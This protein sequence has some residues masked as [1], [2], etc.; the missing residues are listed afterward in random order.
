MRQLSTI[1]AQCADWLFPPYCCLCN[2]ALPS[3]NQ[4]ICTSCYSALPW[5]NHACRQCALPLESGER[6]GTCLCN[7]PAFAH[8]ITPFRYEPPISTLI[9]QLKFQQQLRY[10]RVLGQLLIE[11]IVK[12][13]HSLPEC[14]IPIPLHIQRLKQ[15]G[16]NQALEIAK[17]LSKQLQIPL[18]DGHCY[19]RKNTLPQSQLSARARR[20]NLSAA[21]A[22]REKMPFQHVAIVDDV[23]T[24]GQTVRA[25]SQMLQQQGIQKIDIWCCARAS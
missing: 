4:V 9:I 21:F 8:C 2:K 12:Y 17:P 10:A 5:N 14:I 13:Q 16:F 23:M 25:L 22:I 18:L 1:I 6:C 20:R 3:A 7:P 19:R 11:S 15:R 24:T